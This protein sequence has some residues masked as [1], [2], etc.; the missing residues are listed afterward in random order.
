MFY[1]FG[2]QYVDKN[3]D[4]ILKKYTPEL[5]VSNF[6]VD[7]ALLKEFYSF[8]AQK[9]VAFDESGAMTS[10]PIIKE[11]LKATIGRNLWGDDVFYQIVNEND[12]MVLKAI[13]LLT[14]KES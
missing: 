5:Y 13:Q 1:Q 12:N 9:G 4:E 11:R 2:F 6:K 10:L 8:A 7:E 3:R 14:S